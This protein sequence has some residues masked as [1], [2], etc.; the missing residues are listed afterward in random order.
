MASKQARDLRELN[1]EELHRRLE[2]AQQDLMGV[3]FGLATHQTE[4]T[5]RLREAKRQLARIKTL[6]HEREQEI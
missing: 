3:R 1:D 4:N 6:L 2:E 5:A